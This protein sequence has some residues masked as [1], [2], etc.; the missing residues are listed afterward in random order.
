[1]ELLGPGD[2]GIGPHELQDAVGGGGK[3][4]GLISALAHLAEDVLA[5]L[6]GYIDL[7]GRV[8]LDMGRHDGHALVLV[9]VAIALHGQPKGEVL[10]AKALLKIASKIVEP[11]A[12][13][14]Q[15]SF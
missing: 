3:N 2:E 13:V 11:S 6:A 10:G 12:L 15:D 7:L 4:G 9:G 1:M 14:A 8:G 5:H